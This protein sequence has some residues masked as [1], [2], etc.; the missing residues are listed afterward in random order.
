[1]PLYNIEH[2]Y[3][4]NP[5]QKADLAERITKL[6]AHTFTTPSIFVQVKFQHQDASAQNFFVAGSPIDVSINRIIAYVRSS[7][8]RKKEHFDKL[9]EEIENAWYVVL[10]ERVEGDDEEDKK[11]KEKEQKES[12]EIEKKA[13]E[14]MSVAFVTGI[15]VREKGYTIPEVCLPM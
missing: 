7:S 8:A 15:I 13:K 9:A 10:G 11:K 1:M 6:H 12:S 5:K 2:S 3:P 14:L 4:L